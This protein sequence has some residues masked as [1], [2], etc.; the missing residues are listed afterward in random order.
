RH[1]GHTSTSR[2]RRWLL[3]SAGTRARARRGWACGRW[4]RSSKDVLAADS[5]GREDV[6]RAGR[7]RSRGSGRGRRGE[8]IVRNVVA[9]L[10]EPLPASRGRL[11]E[12]LSRGRP[13]EA[14]AVDRGEGT[15]QG[16]EPI[17]VERE[18]PPP[19]WVLRPGRGEGAIDAFDEGLLED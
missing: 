1:P 6:R 19:A 8:G 14:D 2:V 12:S 17:D 5:R 16:I 11:D 13:P 15:D 4:P 10:A 9:A 18:H 3:A 7:A